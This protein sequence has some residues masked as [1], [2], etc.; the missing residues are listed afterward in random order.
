MKKDEYQPRTYRRWVE[1][2]D[3]AAFTV[4]EKETDLYIR[5]TSDLER[6]ARRLV[7]QIP[8]A[9]RKLHRERADP[10]KPRSSR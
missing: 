2:K 4:T 9:A 1:G 10:F 8:P 7:L 5:A 6:K 3:L